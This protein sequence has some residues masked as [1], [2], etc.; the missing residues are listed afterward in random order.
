MQAY[1]LTA[2]GGIAGLALVEAPDPEPGRGEV[3]I[4]VR[5]TALNHRDLMIARNA[6]QAA[7]PL[8]DGAGEVVAVGA[9]VSRFAAGDRVA[10]CFFPGWSDGE[11]APEYI[12]DALGGSVDG[13]LAERVVLPAAAVVRIP[14]HMTDEEAATLPCAALTAW[15][16]MFEQARLRPGQTVLL[17]G[18]GGVSIVGLQ[19]ARIGGVR[20]I[21][22]SSSNEKLARARALG[23][24]ETINYR[25]RADWERAV[26]DLT[27]GAGV[28]LVLEVGGERT[29]AQS[30]A[31]T[32][33]GGEIV[34]IG[35]VARGE[36]EVPRV[37]LV[38]RNIRATRIYVGSRAMFERMNRALE[39]HR[40][41]P[42][43]DRVFEFAQA[44]DAYRHLES[45]AH[46]GKVVIRV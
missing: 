23:A 37:P 27:G 19:L 9:G 42:V 28:D 8:S 43:I 40:V 14:T 36:G 35:G 30:L 31:A 11:V 32:R 39:L 24:D 7:V 5:A 26:L 41:H 20:T 45:Q 46:V 29:F 38:A 18:T 3:L 12:R 10:G 4:R 17:L 6:R 16:G 15:N 33:L 2:G 22:T 44:A 34:L 1:R 21:I 13:M 25:E